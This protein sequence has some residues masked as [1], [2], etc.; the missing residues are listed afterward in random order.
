MY[1]L[2]EPVMAMAV[3]LMVTLV[4]VARSA[5]AAAAWLAGRLSG[6]RSWNCTVTPPPARCHWRLRWIS[7][8]AMIGM[9]PTP[10]LLIQAFCSVR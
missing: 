1:A 10:A 3:P 2:G 8:L 6:V 9:A 4:V 5:G 7:T